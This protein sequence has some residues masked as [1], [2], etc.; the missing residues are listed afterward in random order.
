MSLLILNRFLQEKPNIN[1][2]ILEASA[3]STPLKPDTLKP[4]QPTP[5]H[6]GVEL[7]T[8]RH[9]APLVLNVVAT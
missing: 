2:K 1:P 5:S 3:R 4:E 9:S 8:F 6:P 7:Y